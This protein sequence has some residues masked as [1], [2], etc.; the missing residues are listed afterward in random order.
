MNENSSISVRREQK[1]KYNLRTKTPRFEHGS[2]FPVHSCSS[3]LK[4]VTKFGTCRKL[5]VIFLEAQVNIKIQVKHC[6]K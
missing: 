1:A 2:F 6:C 3:S 4:H 5:S